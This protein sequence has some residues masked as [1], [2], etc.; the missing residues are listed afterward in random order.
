MRT[1]LIESDGQDTTAFAPAGVPRRRTSAGRRER[2]P[3]RDV[4][5]GSGA[6]TA[7]AAGGNLR[8]YACAAL[9]VAIW[10]G[11]I[12]TSRFG[13]TSGLGAYDVT[14]LR[15]G[16]ASLVLL[17]LWLWRRPAGIF[18]GRMAI[19]A[20]FGGLGYALLVYSGF[21]YVPAAHAAVLLPGLL[22]F[23]IA[24]FT[25]LVTG[26]RPGRMRWLALAVI[27]L[28]VVSLAIESMASGTS[29]IGAMLM[30]AASLSWAIYTVLA[31]HWR[32]SPWSATF[33][34]SL[35]AAALYLPVY[36]AVLPKQI[37]TVAWTIIAAQ[38]FY[39]GVMAMI[40]A[41][42]FYLKAIESIGTART[43]SLMALVPAVSG[44]AAAP[45]LGESLSS[46]ITAG[47][48]LVS[49]GA[50]LGNIDHWIFARRNH[51]V[52]EH[53]HHP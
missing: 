18:N 41:M 23:E 9:T 7:A 32:I 46:W 27:A 29:A 36:L 50:W 20:L 51:A 42:I 2:V 26:E 34:V 47:L 15:L 33:G 31:R 48:L 21:R 49:A 14:A 1:W 43:G 6:P 4:S 12:L 45:I 17:P 11:F 8:G 24:L 37:G 30:V 53:P 16:T 35:I 52:R 5:S 3:R 39:Q 25:W 38:G 10:C 28:G 40:V 22:P 13:G 19:L 44:F